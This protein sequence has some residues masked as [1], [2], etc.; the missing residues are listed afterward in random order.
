METTKMTLQDRI[1]NMESPIARQLMQNLY[2]ELSEAIIVR[3]EYLPFEYQQ[4][5]EWDLDDDGNKFYGAT[6][7]SIQRKAGMIERKRQS[8]LSDAEAKAERVE[9]YRE[10]MEETGQINYKL[11]GE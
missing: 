4:H 8:E 3:N 1:N 9:L 11:K 6:L 7:A 5:K 10:Q 2:D